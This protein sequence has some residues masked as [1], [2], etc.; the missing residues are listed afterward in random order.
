MPTAIARR[1]CLVLWLGCLGSPAAAAQ[2]LAGRAMVISADTIEVAGSRVRL[3]G[4]DAPGRAQTCRRDDGTWDCGQQAALALQRKIGDRPVRCTLRDRV[5]S[6]IIIASCLVDGEDLS[7][8]LLRNGWAI[9]EVYYSYE[10]TR[11]ELLAK[12]E[13]RGIWADGFVRSWNWPRGAD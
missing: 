3:H 8:W 5:T 12:T 11:A 6:G 10:H 9:A 4:I 2:E 13:R 1:A 7:L